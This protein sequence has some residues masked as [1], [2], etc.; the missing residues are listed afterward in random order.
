MLWQQL[1]IVC[2]EAPWVEANVRSLAS[3]FDRIVV[4]DGAA[5]GDGYGK[6]DGKKLTGG[7]GASTD[8]TVSILRELETQLPNLKVVYTSHPWRGKTEM[9]QAA[10]RHMEP[11]WVFQRDVDEFWFEE[12]LQRLKSVVDD[13]DYTD[14]EFYAYHFWGDRAHHMRLSKD[15]WG[16]Q[17]PWRRL[18]RW[19]GERWESHE[20][21]RMVRE[22]EYLLSM[23]ETRALD[24]LMYHYS[25]CDLGQLRKKEIFYDIPGQLVPTIEQWRRDPQSVPKNADLVEFTGQHPINLPLVE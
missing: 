3:F 24:V 9:V 19:K 2:N 1:T 17:I 20:P 25:Y 23:D 7:H 18:F 12:D 22:D 8:G 5:P 6:G 16:N 11:G 4:V 13:S 14:A 15:V 10:M 21:P